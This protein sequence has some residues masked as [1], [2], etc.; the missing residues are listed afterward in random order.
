MLCSNSAEHPVIRLLVES[1]LFQCIGETMNLLLGEATALLVTRVIHGSV[2]SG[3][4]EGY[5]ANLC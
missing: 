1:C 4:E 2:F 3:A 5:E